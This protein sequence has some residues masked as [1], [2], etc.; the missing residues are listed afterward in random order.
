MKKLCAVVLLLSCAPAHAQDSSITVREASEGQFVGTLVSD[1]ALSTED[2]QSR[3]LGVAA[4]A[5]KELTP[6]L[7][8]YDFKSLESISAATPGPDRFE[9]NQNF[10]CHEPTP[11]DLVQTTATVI[12][13]AEKARLVELATS[14]TRKLIGDPDEAVVRE[15]HAKFSPT[16]SSMLPLTV[17]IEQ[18]AEIHKSAGAMSAAPGF[19]V[20]TYIDPPDSPG[21]GVYIAVDFQARYDSAP[22]R[23]GYVIWLFDTQSSLSVLRLEEGIIYDRDAASMTADELARTRQ[24]FRCFAP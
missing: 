18:Q 1:T 8:H 4:S 7:G 2:A 23:C 17:W 19:K 11:T 15:F 16:L 20:T 14:E 21:P 24:Q 6:S 10:T 22:F 12:S 3:V 9:F 5:C 13:D